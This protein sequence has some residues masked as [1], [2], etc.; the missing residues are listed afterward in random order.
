MA[1][2]ATSFRPSSKLSASGGSQCGEFAERMSGHHVGVEVAAHG[3]GKYHR[4]EEYGGL[5]D[6]GLLE[7]FVGAFKH[8]VSDAEAEYFVGFLKHFVRCGIVVVEVFAHA[9]KLGT[10]AEKQMLS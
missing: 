6:F 1:R 4:V 3:L 8:Y 10:L 2:A 7:V 9:D 5:C